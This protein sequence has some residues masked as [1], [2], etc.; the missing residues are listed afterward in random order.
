MAFFEAARALGLTCLLRPRLSG[1]EY[2]TEDEDGYEYETTL[3]LMGN[4]F[5]SIVLG[6]EVDEHDKVGDV[7]RMYPSQRLDDN[8][9]TWLNSWDSKLEEPAL[10]YIVVSFCCHTVLT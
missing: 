2:E 6:H 8:N 4:K 10:A 1:P 5:R 9:V 3:S 7:E